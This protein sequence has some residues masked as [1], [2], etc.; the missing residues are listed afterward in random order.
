MRRHTTASSS[1]S[2]RGRCT[3]RRSRTCAAASRGRPGGRGRDDVR[4]RPSC[5]SP[6][7]G[8]ATRCASCDIVPV[9]EAQLLETVE[10][11]ARPIEVVVDAGN[12]TGGPVAPALYER[13][14]ARVTSLFCDPDG[15]FP[16][17]HPD[18][19][20]VENMRALMARVRETGAE[21]GIAFDGDADRIGVVDG[22][23]RMI[24]GDEL[25]V[26]FARDVL[27]RHPGAVVVSEVK[28][29]QRLY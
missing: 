21:L 1:V 9:Y 6:R 23:G 18:P 22:A 10:P 29:S 15:H 25:L 24:C 4:R 5:R 13:L 19:T 28:C 8:G 16:N 27:S 11:L 7:G 17:H 3:A 2:A 20:V 26:L 12:G 14:G